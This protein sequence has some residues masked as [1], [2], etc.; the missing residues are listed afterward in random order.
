MKILITGGA[1]FVGS[2]LGVLFK[3]R[4]NADV[5]A[6]DNLKRRGSEL[7]ITRLAGAGVTFHHGDI[8][9]RSDLDAVG[10]FDLLIECSAEPSVH[11]GYGSSPDYL[12][13]TNLLGT[14]NCLELARK[15]EA[16]VVFL[17]TSR[18]YP[19]AALRALPLVETGTRLDLPAD[20]RG[21]GY[22]HAGI[23]TDFPLA[24]ARSLYGATKLASEL[25]MEEYIAMYGLRAVINRCGVIAGAWQMGKVDQGFVVLWA[26][27]HLYGGKL[28][29]SG[30]GG[31]GMQVRDILHVHDL[32]DLIC[33]QIAD[34]PKHSGRIHNA[35]GGHA[36]SVSL[37]ELTEMCKERCGHDIPIGSDPQTRAA[38]IPYYITDNA[39][40]TASTGWLPRRSVNDILDEVFQWLAEHREQLEPIL[41]S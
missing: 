29:Y 32:F 24:G 19:I 21:I 40:I 33:K 34:W 22:S 5:V 30:F 26:A 28:S 36:N 16:A 18:V 17:S 3:E 35:G 31:R 37:R 39:E 14:I 25:I 38:D 10:K 1:G 4:G 2:N 41:N 11:A 13:D 20:A 15:H 8:R 9:S 6:L 12:I 27:R 23:R 7:A